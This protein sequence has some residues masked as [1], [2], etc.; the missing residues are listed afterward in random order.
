ME[1]HIILIVLGA[2]AVGILIGLGIGWPR[3][4]YYVAAT[5]MAKKAHNQLITYAFDGED[6]RELDMAMVDIDG[7]HRLLKQGTPLIRRLDKA[8]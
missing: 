4:G 5:A 1:A 8:L 2:I 6:K 7:C 3:R